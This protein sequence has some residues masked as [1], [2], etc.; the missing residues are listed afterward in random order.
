LG[1]GPGLSAQLPDLAESDIDGMLADSSF[2][3]AGLVGGLTGGGLT[4]GGLTG[5]GLT[6][7]GLTG[8]GLTGGD[9]SQLLAAQGAMELRKTSST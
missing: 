8:G 2:L 6:G 1:L 3:G 5:G 9:G 4:G 7:G